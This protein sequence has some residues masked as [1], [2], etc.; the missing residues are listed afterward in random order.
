MDGQQTSTSPKL[1]DFVCTGVVVQDHCG[2]D[3]LALHGRRE[4]RCL[5]AALVRMLHTEIISL[6]RS[7]TD[8]KVDESRGRTA[9]DT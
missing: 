7:S 5:E 4:G 1:S 3:G 9:L 8:W 6:F 2:L